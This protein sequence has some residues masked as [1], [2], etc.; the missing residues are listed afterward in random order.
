M[1]EKLLFEADT[2]EAGSAAGEVGRA[3]Q[4]IGPASLADGVLERWGE[5]VFVDRRVRRPS[6]RWR[7]SARSVI[8]GRG[9]RSFSLRESAQLPEL[10][11][12]V[13]RAHGR[14]P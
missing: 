3:L 8:S 9:I 4:M 6:P 10:R 1:E 7:G 14:A 2:S 12:L 5:R 11:D 13:K